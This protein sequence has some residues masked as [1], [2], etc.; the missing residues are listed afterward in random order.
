MHLSA[1][2]RQGFGATA[3]TSIWKNCPSNGAGAGGIS[4]TTMF[5]WFAIEMSLSSYSPIVTVAPPRMGIV[6]V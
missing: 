4:G 1:D 2:G 6:T 5:W 3:V